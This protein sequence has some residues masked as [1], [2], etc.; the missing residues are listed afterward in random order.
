MTQA[1]RKIA[2]LVLLV[3][4]IISV[5]ACNATLFAQT[6]VT[7]SEVAQP[8]Q[9]G[10]RKFA[11]Q[12]LIVGYSRGVGPTDVMDYAGKIATSLDNAST[13]LKDIQDEQTKERLEGI[14]PKVEDPMYG[15]AWYM[16]T[17]L[18]PSF[19]VVSFQQV[20][21]EDD[22]KRLMKGRSTQ[23]G[24]NSDLT[25]LG[26]G[27]YRQATTISWSSELPANA[28]S[29]M[30]EKNTPPSTPG[31]ELTQK[32]VEK[33]GKKFLESSQVIT[34][35]YRYHDG[36]L[37]EAAFEELYEMELP[38]VESIRSGVDATRDLGFTAWLDRIPLGIRQLGWNML[39]GAVGSQ[40]QQRDE[41]PDAVYNMRRS[42][43]DMG[44]ALVQSFLFDVDSADGWANF[45]GENDGSLRAQLRIQTRRNSSLSG[46]LI[47][48]SGTS[49]F[50]PILSDSAVGTFHLCVRLSDEAPAAL[51][52]VAEWL[53]IG[54]K[55][56][57]GGPELETAA[58]TL[59]GLLLQVA[60]HR[61]LEL[62]LKVGYSKAS[63]G[64]FYGGIQLGDHE[65]LL[66]HAYEV[67]R[68]LPAAGIDQMLSL[69][70]D[71]GMQM[72]RIQLPPESTEGLRTELGTNITHIYLAHQNSCLWFA[73][74]TEKA[75]EIIRASVAR[76]LENSTGA[77]TPLMSGRLDMQQWLALP[78]D[79]P[80]GIAQMPFW[81]DEN[82]WWFPPSP[83]TAGM[84][85]LG[86][87]KPSP[88]MTRVFDL[89]GDQQTSFS[90]EADE[91]GLLLN[92]ALG[93]ALA[94]HMLARMISLQETRSQAIRRQQ[95]ESM[96]ALKK[97]QEEA[98]KNPP[99]LPNP[100]K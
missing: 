83:F 74:G 14:Q 48:S 80:A 86:S 33:D 100:P 9:Q 39:N 17:G 31:Y 50:A 68:R 59:S 87:E 55:E 18:I 7:R 98:S 60:E 34:N 56:G 54:A 57:G 1:F 11:N 24:G 4:A 94:N 6:E 43:G 44:M 26:D 76:C 63:D 99:P 66:R 35:R 2:S 72:I 45:A 30:Y 73:I 3:A 38:N 90:L 15:F 82:R 32:V 28:D 25:E 22:A 93:E 21:D 69:T 27:K 52:A 12:P 88:I 58:A 96:E 49:R 29:S 16:V 53:P 8:P 19:D 70:E 89:G 5:F 42:A 71:G 62:L 92:I 37:Y 64:V 46:R 84:L 51:Q 91:G 95:E 67:M 23:M 47:K 77:K 20:V 78:Q 10:M 65:N 97:A 36:L 40:L 79:D 75:R 41:E 81:L 61:N 85:G 13:L